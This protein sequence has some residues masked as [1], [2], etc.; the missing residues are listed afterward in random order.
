MSILKSLGLHRK[1]L[2]SWAYYDIA[3]SSF[4]V[5]IMVAI[6]PVY[7]VDVVSKDL[8]PNER[9][10]LWAYLSSF[11]MAV[12]A[13]MS[14]VLGAIADHIKGKK[15]FL[16]Y[17]TVSG[18]LSSAALCFSSQ[19]SITLTSVLY[20]LANL[21]FS[22][23][24]LFYEALLPDICD[25]QDIHL[26]SNSGYAIG[27]LASGLILA[28]NLAFITSP[29]T[30]GFSNAEVGIKASFI[31]VGVW[32]L[33]F[34][35]PLFKNVPELSTNQEFDLQNSSMFVLLKDTLSQ[36]RKTISDFS[37]L[38]NLF[39]FLL[40]F[41]FYSDGIGTIMKLA[42]VYGK[43]VGIS[44]DDLIAA[45]LMIQF[46]GVPATFLF[47]PISKRIGAKLSL[48]ITLI[49]YTALTAGSYFMSES[50][51]FW[52]LAIGVALVQG[53]A[54]AL[55]RSIYA[56]MIPKNRTS[57]FFG[58]FSVSSKVAGIFGPLIFGIISQFTGDSKNSLIIICIIFLIGIALLAKVDIKAGQIE[59]QA[60]ERN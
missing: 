14:P 4:A 10:A 8:P 47:G 1:D 35:I 29:H 18:A 26:T 55:S 6:M 51:H 32:W 58:F 21:S 27:Y 45:I 48:Y 24:N 39:I 12:S 7:F 53:A 2:R 30:F 22:L 3:N 38:P 19:G 56:L 25:E 31:S 5:I 49:V 59:A 20:V 46:V 52:V 41:W 34:S 40:S 11:A 17:F 33:V 9:T 13:F 37:S 23:G 36:L 28:L 15:R 50:W 44:N 42:T 60:L 57:E 54:Q 16:L 43:E